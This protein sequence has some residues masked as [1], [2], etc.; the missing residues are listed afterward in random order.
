M[1]SRSKWTFM[2]FV[3]KHT[4][5]ECF[6]KN[7]RHNQPTTTFTF[8]VST[9]WINASWHTLRHTLYIFATYNNSGKWFGEFF[10]VCLFRFYIH[11]STR[12]FY[13]SIPLVVCVCLCVSSASG[14]CVLTMHK[15]THF[16]HPLLRNDFTNNRIQWAYNLIRRDVHFLRLGWHM[17]NT[18]DS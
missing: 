11:K 18:C 10:F 3:N 5:F 14:N 12:W 6:L 2:R 15:S 4:E 7:S 16:S 8:Y 9:L 1:L 13:T 17:S